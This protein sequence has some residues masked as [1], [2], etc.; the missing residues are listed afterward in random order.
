MSMS[1]RNSLSRHRSAPLALLVASSMSLCAMGA[2]APGAAAVEAT[3]LITCV[4]MGNETYC[5]EFGSM[6][7]RGAEDL[8]ADVDAAIANNP[9][10]TKDVTDDGGD[11]SLDETV[12]RLIRLSP[13]ELKER[14]DHQIAEARVVV[15]EEQAEE[16]LT[17][18]LSTI[19]LVVDSAA[20][21]V[22]GVDYAAGLLAVPATA[23]SAAGDQ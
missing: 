17:T 12:A 21:I 11:L 23:V 7:A 15:A 3:D 4:P 2:V 20:M 8:L 18:V 22:L 6:S 10:G 9:D 16:R 14:Q 13:A 19:Q 1:I 5:T